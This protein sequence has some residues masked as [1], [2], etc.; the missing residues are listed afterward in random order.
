MNSTAH[1][2]ALGN[3]IWR[4][5]ARKSRRLVK[6]QWFWNRSCSIVITNNFPPFIVYSVR[7]VVS[8][9]SCQDKQAVSENTAKIHNILF[10]VLSSLFAVVFCHLVRFVL[11]CFLVLCLRGFCKPSF[12][13]VKQQRS[14]PVFS[15][16]AALCSLAVQTLFLLSW[17]LK[18]RKFRNAVNSEIGSWHFASACPRATAVIVG[19]CLKWMNNISFCSQ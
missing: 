8:H 7:I 2:V 4:L 5:F 11:F 13:Q 10:T 3:H 19:G 18:P 6:Y 16:L 12:S 1:L 17:T 9:S 15:A 14:E